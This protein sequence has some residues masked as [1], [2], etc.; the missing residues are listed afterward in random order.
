M[1]PFRAT[2]SEKILFIFKNEKFD[3][4]YE[5]SIK[6]TAP[7]ERYRLYQ[8]MDSILIQEAPVVPLYYDEVIR[9]TQKNVHG[10]GINPIDMLQ[11]KKVRK[12]TNSLSS[13]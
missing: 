13:E 3:A 2:Q 6:I 9:F 5:K 11:L 4:L 8:Q 7:E 12:S 1:F 10:L